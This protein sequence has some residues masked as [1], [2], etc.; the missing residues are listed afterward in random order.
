[1][2][3]ADPLVSLQSTVPI[4]YRACKTSLCVRRYIYAIAYITHIISRQVVLWL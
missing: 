4:E 3:T 2:Q 1:M